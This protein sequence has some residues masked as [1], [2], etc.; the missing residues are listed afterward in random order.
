MS[1]I[2]EVETGTPSTTLVDRFDELEKTM[3]R[4]I[5]NSL[6]Q[7]HFHEIGTPQELMEYYG[8]TEQFEEHERAKLINDT[9]KRLDQE[10]A[11]LRFYQNNNQILKQKY[12]EKKPTG[13]LG[14][15]AQRTDRESNQPGSITGPVEGDGTGQ[16][17]D[18]S[19]GHGELHDEADH[20]SNETEGD[21]GSVRDG[22]GETDITG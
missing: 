12:G 3:E 22:L 2:N 9:L 6:I 16:S 21:A 15:T 17:A 19:T 14:L 8:W 18:S 10:Q 13:D 5:A 4:N 1:D 20:G 7:L 11:I